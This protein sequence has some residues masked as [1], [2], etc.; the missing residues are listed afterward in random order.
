[1]GKDAESAEASDQIQT[2]QHRLLTPGGWKATV[3]NGQL[4]MQLAQCLKRGEVAKQMTLGRRQLNRGD[5]EDG[6][7]L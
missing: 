4:T 3:N 2:L 6:G 5:D 1:M 7:A